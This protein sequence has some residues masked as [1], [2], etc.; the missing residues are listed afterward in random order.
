MPNV[1]VRPPS[2]ISV[3]IGNQNP[4]TV[5]TTNS[6][7]RTLK[8]ASDLNISGGQTG[9]VITYDANTHGFS[10]TNINNSIGDIDGGI[11]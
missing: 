4:S 1:T 11:F 2:T 7:T 3:R 6:G 5:Q 9:D 8:S 10:V